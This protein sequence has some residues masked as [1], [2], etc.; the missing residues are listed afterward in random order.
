M[1]AII[2]YHTEIAIFIARVFLGL[3]FFFQG[4]DAIFNVKIDNIIESFYRPFSA[5]GIPKSLTV[6]GVWFT[7]YIELIGGLMLVLGLFKYAA[8]YLLGADI[9]IA[10]IGFGIVKPMWDMQFVFPRLILL[11]FLLVIPTS[12]DIASIDHL[13]K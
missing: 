8:L 7:S 10:S 11:I 4:Y 6:V 2:D 9:L 3:L 5:K 12:W 1:Q 13:I